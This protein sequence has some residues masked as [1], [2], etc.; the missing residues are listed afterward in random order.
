M[1]WRDLFQLSV[2]NLKRRKLRTS[3]TMIGVMI[4]TASIVSMMSIGLA[5]SRNMQETLF[6]T[7]SLTTINVN[8]GGERYIDMSEIKQSDLADPDKKLLTDDAVEELG[9]LPGIQVISPVIQFN[10][11]LKIGNRITD[12]NIRGMTFD[13]I[14]SMR[15]EVVEGEDIK[16]DA[17]EFQLMLGSKVAEYLYIPKNPQQQEDE[18]VIL[19]IEPYNIY[20]DASAYYSRIY[21]SKNSEAPQA[22]SKKSIIVPQAIVKSPGSGLAYSKID[23]E[24]LAEIGALK[25]KLKE[26]FRRRAWPGQPKDKNGKPLNRLVYNSV[27]IR[28]TDLDAT[29]NMIGMIKDMGYQPQSEL[30][31]IEQMRKQAA[32][33]QMILG[34]IGAISLL[35]AAIGIA[36]TMMMTIYERTREIGIYKVLGCRLPLIRRMFLIESALIGFIG[37]ALGIILSLIVSALLNSAASGIIAEFGSASYI[38]YIPLWLVLIS[39]VFAT[40]IGVVAGLA[41]A[42][43]AMKLSALEA[44]RT[45]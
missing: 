34:G 45:N 14:K 5:I 39:I 10:A 15:Y 8:M 43:R 30:E 19:H 26:E 4:G 31:F 37:G 24:G 20:L 29:K 36:N 32:V 28:A 38:S 7:D 18:P 23:S 35:V 13:A 17:S 16:P 33:Q 22:V 2:T 3:L 1:K 40:L 42:N 21:D 44:L 9:K 12:F 41:P 25:R 27:Y 11:I 6:E